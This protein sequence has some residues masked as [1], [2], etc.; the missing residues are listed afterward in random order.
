MPEQEIQ[1]LLN[2][3]QEL[4]VSAKELTAANETL[5]AENTR[6]RNK[7]KRMNELLLLIQQARFGLSS[8]KREYVLKGGDQ[9]RLFNKAEQL[10]DPKAPE[11]TQETLVSANTR[12]SKRPLDKLVKNLPVKKIV[13]EL[14]ENQRCCDAYGSEL[15]PIEEKLLRQEL[16]IIPR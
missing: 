6:L 8:E 13:L 7:L 3:V 12:K 10:Q 5:T 14:G 2:T 9:I 4:T 11:A 15:T 16:I 1:E